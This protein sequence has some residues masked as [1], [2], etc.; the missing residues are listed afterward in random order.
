VETEMHCRSYRSVVIEPVSANR[1]RE[2]GNFCGLGRRL[3]AISRQG[4]RFL[5]TGDPGQ[6]HE[7]P[8]KC[9]N[10]NQYEPTLSG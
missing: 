10:F 3:S 5:K 6:P 1:L 7:N 9:G 4:C 2:N 8:I